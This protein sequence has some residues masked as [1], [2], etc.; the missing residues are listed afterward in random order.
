MQADQETPEPIRVF[1]VDDHR[2]V[3]C[4]VA[5]YLEL[6]EDIEVVGEAKD[7]Q[8]ALDGIAVLEPRGELPDVVLMDLLMPVMDG[9][10]A[11]RRIKQRWPTVE[12]VAVTSF[13]EED[14]VRG[15]LEA[16]AAGYLLKDADA[17][18]LSGA[19]R[20]AL[21]GRMHLDPTVARLL[22]DS[23]HRRHQNPAEILTPRQTEVLVL[24][25][26]GASNRQVADALDVGERTARTHVS[27][28]LDRLGLVS[29]TQAALW[30]IRQ[31]IV[32]SPRDSS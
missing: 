11:T 13:V 21:A 32:P 4:G 5:A 19:I 30:A 31:G 14:K 29:R 18:E 6:I 23:T 1:L 25:A 3:R 10:T 22:A 2:V 17:D 24:V 7:G 16:G 15:A 20:A 8:Q 12:I 9:V 26:Q 27:D 28:I